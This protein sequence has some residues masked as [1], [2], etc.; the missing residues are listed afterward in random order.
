MERGWY[1]LFSSA[2]D[3][4]SSELYNTWSILCEVLTRVKGMVEMIVD[5]AFLVAPYNER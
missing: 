5:K 1:E 4:C 3:S 2:V